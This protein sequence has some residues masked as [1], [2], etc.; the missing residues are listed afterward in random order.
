MNI[1]QSIFKAY[2]I[3]GIAKHDLTPEN[4]KLLGLAIGS[5]SIS[6]GERNIVIGRDGR[7]SSLDLM[8]ALTE[9]LK[10]WVSYCGYWYG[11]NSFGIFCNAY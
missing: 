3:R 7:L 9:G 5:E 8:Q 4:V 2:D 1:S 10:K 6:K 11:S